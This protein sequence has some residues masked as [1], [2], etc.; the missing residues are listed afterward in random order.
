M[1]RAGTVLAASARA[2]ACSEPAAQSGS[3][4]SGTWRW[5]VQL[6]E[7]GQAR[8][9]LNGARSASL[10]AK[11]SL[12]GSGPNRTMTLLRAQF[13]PNTARNC[14]H[15]WLAMVSRFLCVKGKRLARASRVSS[16]KL[17]MRVR[18]SSPAPQH[19]SWWFLERPRRFLRSH[20]LRFRARN[21]LLLPALRLIG[22][23][24]GAVGEEVVAF[25]DEEFARSTFSG[26]RRALSSRCGSV[27][28]TRLRTSRR[29]QPPRRRRLPGR[30]C[31]PRIFAYSPDRF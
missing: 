7:A 30:K 25:Y 18:F 28:P 15:S 23:S 9:T 17:V 22:A 3:N 6:F 27:R 31:L 20:V 10:Q 5:W 2:R 4:K 8:T 29:R 21:W 14:G 26:Q 24:T 12:F 11:R 1:N 16:S 19:H 13:V